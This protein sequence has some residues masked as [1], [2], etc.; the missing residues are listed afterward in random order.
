MKVKDC[1]KALQGGGRKNLTI[2]LNMNQTMVMENVSIRRGPK[3][4]KK[5][6]CY[7]IRCGL[8]GFTSSVPIKVH[9]IEEIVSR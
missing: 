8:P 9:Q 2:R 5:D 6:G 1:A 3:Y 4:V 7:T